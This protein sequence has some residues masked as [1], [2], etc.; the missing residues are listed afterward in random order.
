MSTKTSLVLSDEMTTKGLQLVYEA[1]WLTSQPL[2]LELPCSSLANARNTASGTTW[3]YSEV[4]FTWSFTLPQV[5]RCACV[6]I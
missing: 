1:K 2:Q 3:R 4:M 6:L 5:T